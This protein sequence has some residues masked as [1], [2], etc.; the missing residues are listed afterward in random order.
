MLGVC[1]TPNADT[2][3]LYYL[4]LVILP[5]VP[6]FL[7]TILYWTSLD[8]KYLNAVKLVSNTFICG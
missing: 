8:K 7:P 6:P 4:D 1:S 3:L 2:I 5:S